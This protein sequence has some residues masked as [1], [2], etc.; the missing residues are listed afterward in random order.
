MLAHPPKYRIPFHH[1]LAYITNPPSKLF[2]WCEHTAAEGGNTPVLRSSL[3]V[4]EL[5]DTH[6]AFMSQLRE[7]GVRYVRQIEARRDDELGDFQ[8][9]WQDVFKTDDRAEAE[10]RARSVGTAEV[11]WVDGAMKCTTQRFE[12]VVQG[13][14]FNSIC[15]LHPACAKLDGVEDPLWDAQFG[16]GT[17]ISDADALA[18]RAALDRNG[19]SFAWQ[20]GDILVVDNMLALHSREAFSNSE[21]GPRRRILA[22]MVQ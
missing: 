12:G 20:Q 6:P 9:S 13:A 2:F 4:T 15:L 18:A 14:F 8:R 7:K 1:E 17:P 16:D 3:V 19:A 5:D 21:S 22:A 10:A 11:E